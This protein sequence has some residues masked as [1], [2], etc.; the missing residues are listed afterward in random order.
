[1]SH[2]DLQERTN[3]WGLNSSFNSAELFRNLFDFSILHQSGMVK[4]H[5][6]LALKCSVC[7]SIVKACSDL[8]NVLA[9]GCF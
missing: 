5:L 3:C 6:E 9:G 2:L 7:E 4:P 1:M 8:G